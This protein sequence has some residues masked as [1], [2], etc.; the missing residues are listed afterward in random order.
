MAALPS[1]Q[2]FYRHA[3]ESGN[4]ANAVKIVRKVFSHCF[5]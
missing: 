3:G 1:T 4:A 5:V 2:A